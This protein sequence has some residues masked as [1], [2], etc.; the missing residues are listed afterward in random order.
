MMIDIHMN[1]IVGKSD[2]R[3]KHH[4]SSTTTKELMVYV[5]AAVQNENGFSP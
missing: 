1:D 5:D 3:R 4:S 2:A